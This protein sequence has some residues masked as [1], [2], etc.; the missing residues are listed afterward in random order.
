M[1]E[2]LLLRHK[3]E[4]TYSEISGTISWQ[5]RCQDPSMPAR[6][7]QKLDVSHSSLE[8]Q[9]A[10]TTELAGGLKRTNSLTV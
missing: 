3:L 9:T 7:A 4:V 1:E 8:K 2:R 6:V 10:R 5:R